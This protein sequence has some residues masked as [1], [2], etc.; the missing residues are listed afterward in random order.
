MFEIAG[1]QIIRLRGLGA[2]QKRIVIRVGANLGAD[3]QLKCLACSHNVELRWWAKRLQ[4]SGDD[5][6][7][8]ENDTDHEPGR[9]WVSRRSLRIAAISASI[10]SIDS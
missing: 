3:A 8:V 10:S 4:Q 9:N 1:H 2:F 7:G 6:V 5:Y